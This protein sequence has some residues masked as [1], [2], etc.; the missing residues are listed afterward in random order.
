MKKAPQIVDKHGVP[1]ALDT[2]HFAASQEAREFR[3]WN[4]M[5]S[6]GDGSILDEH[7]TIKARALDL[8]RNNGVA[9][10]AI[11]THLD[12][13]VGAGLRLSA[14]PDYKLLGQTPEWAYEWAKGVESLWRSFAETKDFDAAR[15]QTFAGQTATVLRSL[16]VNGE[17]LALPIWLPGRARSVWATCFQLIDPARLSNPMGEF[18]GPFQRGGIRL[19]RYGEPVA[20]SIRRSHPGD[21]MLSRQIPDSWV[22]IP[23]RTRS[24][25]LRV[26]HGF[27][28]QREGQ[29]RGISVLAPVMAAFKM[30][31][32]Y[33]KTE[34]QTCIV[35]AMIA[36]FIETPLGDQAIADLFGGS[37][38][39]YINARNDHEVKL[40]GAAVIPLYPGDKASAFTPARPGTS[41]GPFVESV[42]RH[43]STGLNLPY[44]LLMKDFSK[45]N[46][47]SARAALLEAWRYFNS[48][49]GWLQT[50][51]CNP[52]FELWLEE[53]IDK[54][55]VDAPD[56]E[57]NRYAYTRSVWIG[58]GRGWV[59]PVKEAQ[60]AIS[61]MDSNLSTL[62]RECAE[63]GLDWEEVLEQ[64][65]REKALLE[66]L[67]LA[68][69]EDE[70]RAEIEQEAADAQDQQDDSGED[71]GD[72]QQQEDRTDA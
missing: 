18:D 25:R 6:S 20:Y 42:L 8:Q 68:M 17:F 15:A 59:D 61:R 12:N 5:L 55:L 3:Y 62:E 51:W 45:T 41:Y 67:G 48:I 39:D 16:L 47:S 34:L 1:L 22:T 44:E 19:G 24:G 31:D 30:L 33:Q 58:P 54:G 64:R 26:L 32:Q 43:I 36:A 65:A 70:M 13:I 69:S 37:T 38:A 56:F 50:N 23:A 53:A 66:E 27:E 46:Y 63:Q 29:H 57:A 40:E 14:K 2:H 28:V 52:V 21:A 7:E 4:P 9:S 72:N 11:R 10:G 60:A 35:N 49:R 71:A